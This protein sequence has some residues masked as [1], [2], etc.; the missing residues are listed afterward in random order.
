[1]EFNP[2]TLA[3]LLAWLFYGMRRLDASAVV[4]GGWQRKG[5][6]PLRSPSFEWVILFF[7][8][9]VLVFDKLREFWSVHVKY[10]WQDTKRK[11]KYSDLSFID[12]RG[13]QMYGNECNNPA[14]DELKDIILLA[15]KKR[16]SDIFLDP[17]AGNRVSVRFRADGSLVPI[18]TLDPDI[19]DNVV[20]AVKVAAGM[21]ISEKRRPQDG[22]FAA[23]YQD[24]S[25]AFRVATVG[26]FGGEKVAI[27]LLGTESGP[28]TLEEIG[29]NREQLALMRRSVALPSGMILMCGNTGSGKT[30]TLYA[31]VG[32]I[33]YSLRN[34]ISI[35]DPVERVLP[36][37]SQM[38]V[39]AKAGITFASL[40]RNALR[41]NPDVICLGEI[42]DE[43]T[44]EIA[45]HAAQTGHL[46]IS[47]VHSNDAVDT[48]DRLAS[49]GI[50]LRSLAATI[51]IIVN[52]RLARRLCEHCK[53]PLGEMPEKW[54]NYFTANGIDPSGACR[55][56][57]CPECSGTGYR[58]RCA[59]FDILVI[60]S[61]LREELEK[62]DASLSRVK[63]LAE[64]KDATGSSLYHG[65]TLV[66][67]G[68]I[69]LEELER[70]T[71]T[72]D[73]GGL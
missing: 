24:D 7:G 31:L 35:E 45:V 30:T 64:A 38:E 71:M 15:L 34:V 18:K 44:A 59:C 63:Q 48:L 3:L 23:R 58:G 36:N 61:G 57:G 67:A 70:I 68:S 19:G 32:N 2:I 1:M 39:N 41:Q 46:I 17:V 56:V 4:P 62:E 53:Q 72:L 20:N 14:I 60:D 73:G 28:R 55:P 26:A 47:T 10:F 5:G 8:P 27:R 37:V 40:L 21:D 66:A 29:F 49:L 54:R 65:A 33:D 13:N 51:R 69:S 43:E 9:A 6:G 52:Q 11:I 22:S 50:P 25:A 42:R 16:A 12:A